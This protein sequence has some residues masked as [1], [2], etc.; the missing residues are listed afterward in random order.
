M[1]KYT[2][3]YFEN[4]SQINSLI[5]SFWPQMF[6]QLNSLST[7]TFS[8]YVV[9]FSSSGSCSPINLAN[10]N[11]DVEGDRSNFWYRFAERG[12]C[13][14]LTVCLADTHPQQPQLPPPHTHCQTFPT[15]IVVG[16]TLS[17][18]WLPKIVC[19]KKPSG[20]GTLRTKPVGLLVFS[21]QPSLVKFS[22]MWADRAKCFSFANLTATSASLN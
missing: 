12:S 17:P 10:L 22:Q 15:V 14:F 18:Q 6:K 8:K 11:A 13:V 16:P 9:V 7:Q 4:T 21:I 2:P 3:Y 1:P 5:L 20:T 19:R